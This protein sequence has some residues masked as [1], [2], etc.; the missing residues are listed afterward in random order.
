M[1]SLTPPIIIR[2][3]SKT[4]AATLVALGLT[5]LFVVYGGLLG[6]GGLER[7][8]FNFRAVY[9]VREQYNEALL[10]GF[11]YLVPW[12]AY[13]VNIAFLIFFYAKKKWSLV[14]LTLAG[15]LI[16]F[17]MTNFKSFLFVPFVAL[18]IAALRERLSL[19]ALLGVGITAALAAGLVIFSLGEWM[20]I[21]LVRR[22]FFVPAA[23]HGIY[24]DYFSVAPSGMLSGTRFA[25]LFASPYGSTTVVEL[26]ADM[27]WGRKINP[28]VG[29]V[30]DAFAQFGWYGVFAYATILAGILKVADGL[31]GGIDQRC[32]AVEGLLVGPAIALF[33]SSLTAALLTHGLLVLLISLW[34]LA[35]Y[36]RPI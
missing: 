32:R 35:R 5:L 25:G 30:G 34:A 14:L 36:L 22:A 21:S 15:Q 16:L 3:P 4:V 12:A 33:S 2:P 7:F 6:T 29:W 11:G 13:I 17:G 27:Y 9:G 18:S 19:S 31:A 10:P 1:V 8:N 28:N 24:F 26:I 23:M 20:A